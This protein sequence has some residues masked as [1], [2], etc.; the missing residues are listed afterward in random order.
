MNQRLEILQINLGKSRAASNQ[1]EQGCQ[2]IN[3]SFVC[4]QDRYTSGKKISGIPIEYNTIAST[5]PK[6]AILIREENCTIFPLIVKQNIV[7]IQCSYSNMMIVIINIYIPPF[8]EFDKTVL[9]LDSIISSQQG[10]YLI[11]TGDLNSEK[12][13]MRETL[14]MKEVN[15]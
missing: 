2:E 4:I 9:E 8:S 13:Y 3:P 7:A 5:T 15:N 6:C 1:L 12:C 14:M 10:K 11:L